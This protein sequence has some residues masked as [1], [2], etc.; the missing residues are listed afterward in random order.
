MSAFSCKRRGFT[1]IELLVVIAII[2]I[3][4]ALL[5]PAVQKVREAAARLQC[6][7]NLKQIG[8]ALQS[9]ESANKALPLGNHGGNGGTYGYS[10]RLFILPYI[11]QGAL[12]DLIDQ[13]KSSWSAAMAPIDGK[14]IPAFRC[15]SSTLPWVTIPLAPVGPIYRD[16][17]MVS[18]VGVAG[19]TA[20]AFA[21]SGFIESRQTNGANTTGC[22]TGGN[23][24]AGG[25][26][27]PN[28]AIRFAAI[29]DG[30]S[31]TL[32]VSE[33][34]D[35]LTQQDGTQVEWGTS[36]HGWL[37]GTSQTAIPGQPAYLAVDSR[38][39][40]LTSIRYQLNQK[41]GW[42]NGGDCGG[43][44]VCPNFGCNVPLNSCHIGGVNAG[45][46]DG[47]VRFLSDSISLLT[48]AEIATRDDGLTAANL[49]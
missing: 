26:L 3:L 37:I 39:F 30:T 6:Q 17:Q 11:D 14:V 8:L 22:C 42:P 4:I 18:Y 35:W 24:T 43:T 21:G 34:S 33:Q 23:V 16:V 32:A 41:N 12:Y 19:G 2:A 36:F 29:T 25:V 49:D 47:S 44:G 13:S 15:P 10:W 20:E 45:F 48:L 5:V 1:L 40:G 7:N 31:N 46:C 28:Q 27:V 38:M 9:Y